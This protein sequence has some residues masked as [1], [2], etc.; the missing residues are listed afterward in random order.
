MDES[1]VRDRL[2][3]VEDPGLDGDIVSLGLV[4]EVEVGETVHIDLALGAPYSPTETAIAGDVREALSDLGREVELSA[5]V[6]RPTDPEEEVLPG[7]ENIIAV[8]SGKGGVGKSTVAVNLAA[9]LADLGAEVG[10]FDADIYGPNVPRMV[11]ADEV[12]SATEDEEIIPPE[13]FGMKLMSM[14]FLVGEDDPVIFR[15]PMVHNV[16]TQLWEDVIWG[17]L[18]YMVVD[19]P[20]GTGD[21]Q[22][23]LLQSV[24]VSGAVIVTTPQEVALDDARKG[25]RM[26]GRHDTPVLGV[27]EN[28]AGFVCPDCG[29]EHAIFGEGGGERFAADVDMPFLGSVPLDPAVREGGDD[30]APM[31]HGD[32]EAAE[33]LREFTRKTANMQGIV[34]RRRVSSTRT[35]AE[36]DA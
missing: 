30:G 32:A 2:R 19:L 26:F 17:R 4:N 35:G 14:D 25:L 21:T 34:H 9:G 1:D 5:S 28:M 23:S 11:D 36:P 18:D 16:L 6:D 24:P 29:S 13:Q 15:G 31:V 7:V 27:V 22:L 10:L 8:A 33:A 12:P 20:P 3:A